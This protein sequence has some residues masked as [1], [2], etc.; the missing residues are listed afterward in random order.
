MATSVKVTYQNYKSVIVKTTPNMSLKAVINH[1]CNQAKDLGDPNNYGLRWKK[2]DLDLSL[3]IR[4][5]NLPQGANLDLVSIKLSSDALISIA[6]QLPDGTRIR[7]DLSPNS[8]LKEIYE[9]LSKKS[10]SEVDSI[11]LLILNKNYTGAQILSST[12]AKSIGCV[13]GSVLVRVI[14]GS[15]QNINNNNTQVR[16]EPQKKSNIFGQQLTNFSNLFNK[17]SRPQNITETPKKLSD[18]LQQ[19]ISSL[20]NTNSDNSLNS[21]NTKQTLQNSKGA[22]FV[23]NENPELKYS[24]ASTHNNNSSNI[25]VNHSAGTERTMKQLDE[26]IPAVETTVDLP[27]NSTKVVPK[28]KIVVSIYIP[29]SQSLSLSEKEF[30]VPDSFYELTQAEAKF[31]FEE[32]R[33]MNNQQVDKSDV[34][35]LSRNN[36]NLDAYEFSTVSDPVGESTPIQL[37]KG[38]SPAPITSSHKNE[39]NLSKSTILN[40]PSA[41]NSGPKWL[42]HG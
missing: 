23:S 27:E 30:E 35:L 32:Q 28:K 4:F 13:S 41:S 14:S 10:L 25:P 2:K 3:N 31:L 39:F 38:K 9:T 16:E 5:A 20:E 7:G 40:N 34:A 21:E 29:K 24:K 26:K 17:V 19:P 8:T 36:R 22:D 37:N 11:S 18:S 42:K 12:T 6:L 1:V 33:N 15:L